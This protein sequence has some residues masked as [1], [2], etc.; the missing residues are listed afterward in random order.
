MVKN[1]NFLFDIDGTLTPSRSIIDS[2][3]QKF[4]LKWMVDKNIYFVT[5]SDKQKT[6]EQIGEQIWKNAKKC[7]QSCGNAVYENGVLIKK[8]D[9]L[10]DKNLNL[11]LEN[12]LTK[13]KWKKKYNIHIDQRIGLIN[14]STIGRDCP[15]DER[16]NYYNWDCSG[17]ELLKDSSRKHLL[18]YDEKGYTSDKR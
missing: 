15:R 7:Y 16:N 9:F 6:I 13:S 17:G 3:F 2:D 5:G 11:F 8:I 10:I 4:F 1:I 12:L 14:F 18:I